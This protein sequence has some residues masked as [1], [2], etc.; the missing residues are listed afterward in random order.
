M[1]RI[2]IGL[3]PQLKIVE[4]IL[5]SGL[6]FS[7]DTIEELQHLGSRF[8]LFCDENVH[9]VMGKKWADHLR[10]AGLHV[11][12]FTIPPGEKE[13]N[14]ESKKALEDLL[15]EHKFGSDT[16][17][18]ALGGGVTCDLIAYL[19]STFC[20]G[21]PLVLVPTTLLA[22]VD[23]AIG[24]KTGVNTPYGKNLVGTF[25][26]ADRI[27]IDPS[28]LSTLDPSESTNGLA[29]IIKYALTLSPELFQ[30][31]WTWNPHDQAYLE[32]IIH[33][34]ILLKA[35]IVEQDF[36]EKTGLRR[37]LNFGHTIGHALEL[38][39]NYTLAHG[40]AVAMGMLTESYISYKMG[41]LSEA[42]FKEIETMIRSFPFALLISEKV[43][44]QK[45]QNALLSDKKNARGKPRFVLLD[46]IGA[47]NAFGGSY[48]TDIPG[49]ILEDALKWMFEQFLVRS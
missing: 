47:C 44:M 31:L 26:P 14:R 40:E 23:A 29:E 25:Y 8:A 4:A 20:R 7:E 24:G 15:F 39:E 21:V 17:I 16:C 28:L 22:M 45:M 27:F 34:C 5:S 41:Y 46:K 1:K 6:L 2:A 43:D 18:I 30:H 3:Q 11:S 38:I 36:E 12:V 9:K 19:A 35:Q 48:C 49:D 13:K 42:E 10:S 33:D 37:V 32:R